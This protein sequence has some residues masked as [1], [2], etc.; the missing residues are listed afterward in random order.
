MK[1]HYTVCNSI[2]VILFLGPGFT[3]NAQI[4]HKYHLKHFFYRRFLLLQCSIRMSQLYGYIIMYLN[5]T[6]NPPTGNAENLK[7]RLGNVSHQSFS[8]FDK[9]III[10]KKARILLFAVTLSTIIGGVLSFKA[11]RFNGDPAYT[12]KTI[13]ST[14][15]TFY[16]ASIS[17]CVPINP[18]RFIST[19][20]EGPTTVYR[21]T[22]TLTTLAIS[23]TIFGGTATITFPSN[24]CV[25]V[26]NTYLTAIN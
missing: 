3:Y 13:Y 22:G 17:A 2:A 15:G 4:S 5:L 19:T 12:F 16:T 10:M 26:P 18:A 14:F 6:I 11:T 9:K 8:F 21:K 7:K 1:I 24:G 23:F 20:G 25:L